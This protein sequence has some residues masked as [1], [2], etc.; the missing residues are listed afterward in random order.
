MLVVYVFAGICP[1]KLTL[2][3]P[4]MLK[5]GFLSALPLLSVFGDAALL[6]LWPTYLLGNLFFFVSN[7]DLMP[8]I[9]AWS[10]KSTKSYWLYLLSIY[11]RLYSIFSSWVIVGALPH[12]LGIKLTAPELMENLLPKGCGPSLNTNPKWASHYI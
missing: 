7:Q 10:S 11:V 8:S 4:L 5:T 2:A 1:F 9:L 3:V 12:G 6:P